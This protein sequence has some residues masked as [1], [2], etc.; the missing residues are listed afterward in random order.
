MSLKVTRVL[1]PHFTMHFVI[2]ADMMII[3][4]TPHLACHPQAVAVAEVVVA[5]I[6]TPPITMAMKTTMMTTT[7]MITMTIVVATMI[8]IMAMKKCIQ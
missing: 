4:T 1:S 7:V 3:T 2:C 8:P 5:A 6:L